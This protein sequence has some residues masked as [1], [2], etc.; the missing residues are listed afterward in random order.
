MQEY[1]VKGGRPLRLGY[2]TGSCATAAAAAAAGMLLTGR[3]LESVMIAL[4][5][6]ERV[7]FCLDDVEISDSTA[8]CSVKKDAGD[9]PDVTDGIRIFA[10]C[11]RCADGISI[12]G[13]D[14]VGTVTGDGLA[15]PRGEAAINPVPRRMIAEN[16]RAVCERHGYGGGMT[17]EISAPGGDRIALKTFNPRLGIEGGISILGTTGIVEPMSE[18]AVV[19]TIRLLI[20][21]RKLADPENILITPGNYAQAFCRDVLGIDMS[22]SVKFSN[23]LGEC[24]DYLVYKKFRRILLVGHAGKMFKA[25]GGVMDTHSLVADC[26]ME[27]VAAHAACAGA[28]V[29]TVRALMDCKSTDEAVA[30]LK[31]SPPAGLAKDTFARMLDKLMFHLEYRL[32][33]RAE[34]GDRP[35]GGPEVGVMVFSGNELLMQSANAAALAALFAGGKS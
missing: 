15:I 33:L 3:P 16:V 25:A 1:I 5:S 19:D 6:G 26:R 10:R 23:F 20:D 34:A 8:A 18:K 11:S 4:P 13:G 9:D 21:K 35:A 27:V 7:A 30:L 31:N 12:A 14:G 29:A 2:T 28:G 24:L 17:I 22:L 32:A